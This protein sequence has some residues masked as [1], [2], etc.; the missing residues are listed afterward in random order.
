MFVPKTHR[1]DVV[2]MSVNLL[3]SG[4]TQEADRGLHTVPL[5]VVE[6]HGVA[7]ATYELS[8]LSVQ[9]DRE[10]SDPRVPRI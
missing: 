8:R 7:A 3:E 10:N 4:E 6:E 1:V 9:P 5:E 2:F